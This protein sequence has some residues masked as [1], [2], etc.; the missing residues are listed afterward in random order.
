MAHGWGPG[1]GGEGGG[2]QRG[3]QGN[4]GWR[5]GWR[6]R[7]AA[8]VARRRGSGVG[9]SGSH[10][11]P[12]QPLRLLLSSPHSAL[13]A[14]PCGRP[15][16]QAHAKVAA[17]PQCG[18]AATHPKPT[19]LHAPGALLARGAAAVPADASCRACLSV[20]ACRL[21]APPLLPVPRVLAFI[22]HTPWGT[23]LLVQGIGEGG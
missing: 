5:K 14:A 16:S 9:A 7:E 4:E 17:A 23:Q 2:W 19:Q 1:A 8:K 18:K 11:W 6:V 20:N 12:G 21:P 22:K 10:W 3:A 13:S 15:C